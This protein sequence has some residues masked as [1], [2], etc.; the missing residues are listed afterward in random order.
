[1]L[2]PDDCLFSHSDS[3]NK[4]FSKKVKYYTSGVHGKND[5]I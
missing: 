3:R 4:S 1:M 2:L 5:V